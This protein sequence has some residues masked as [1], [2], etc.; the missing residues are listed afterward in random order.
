MR[1]ARL[2]R[3]AVL[4]DQA[5]RLPRRFARTE[6]NAVRVHERALAQEAVRIGRERTNTW[7]GKSGDIEP[8]ASSRLMLIH[9]PDLDTLEIAAGVRIVE[10]TCLPVRR[11]CRALEAE[12][13]FRIDDL[14]ALPGERAVVLKWK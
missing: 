3:L 9:P 10:R 1:I 8:L 13:L 2:D 11:P 7:R 4:R 14:G 5:R 6:R 12:R